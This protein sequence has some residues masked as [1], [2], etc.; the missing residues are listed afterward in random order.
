MY[1]S[2]PA[3]YKTCIT[4]MCLLLSNS[5]QKYFKEKH[6]TLIMTHLGK[7]LR[8]NF[9]LVKNVKEMISQKSMK[10]DNYIL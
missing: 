10:L 2:I 8:V 7:L 6:S 3:I 1:L 4:K 5:S 9:S